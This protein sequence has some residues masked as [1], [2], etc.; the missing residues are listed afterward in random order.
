MS[1]NGP[2]PYPYSTPPR[3][4]PSSA[5]HSGAILTP[6]GMV[7]SSPS[8]H[9][10]TSNTGSPHMTPTM[11]SNYKVTYLVFY[12][13]NLV[14]CRIK[15][16]HKHSYILLDIILLLISLAFDATSKFDLN[17]NN[18]PKWNTFSS[19]ARSGFQQSQSKCSSANNCSNILS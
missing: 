10:P 3:L 19:M 2:N 1:H 4:P 14:K 16:L 15:K 7:A 6:H 13:K 17:S 12:T 18:F 11:P 9:L 5:N 8:F